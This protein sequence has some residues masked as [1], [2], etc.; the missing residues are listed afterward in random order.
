M[1]PSHRYCGRIYQGSRN[2]HLSTDSETA[3]VVAVIHRRMLPSRDAV[4]VRR[5]SLRELRNGV[6]VV[7]HHTQLNH[8]DVMSFCYFMD[9]VLAKLF[10]L[11]APKHIVSVCRYHLRW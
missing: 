11:L 6:D 9:D 8:E 3:V 5:S 10:I 2:F 1:C 4:V 7:G